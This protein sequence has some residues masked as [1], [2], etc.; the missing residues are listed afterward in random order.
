MTTARTS[1]FADASR[2]AARISSWTWTF[3]AFIFG[4]SSRI[5]PTP[6]RTVRLTNSP[7]TSL[8]TV[9]EAYP[10]VTSPGTVPDQSK[11]GYC[12]LLQLD[13]LPRDRGAAGRVDDAERAEAHGAI[14]LR[15]DGRLLARGG[16][17]GLADRV[18]E[19]ADH[20]GVQV[21]ADRQ[22][23]LTGGVRAADVRQER[24]DL[25]RAVGAGHL[26]RDAAPGRTVVRNA[27]RA[28]DGCHQ[29]VVVVDR[30]QT[31]GLHL[32]TLVLVQDPVRRG[33]HPRRRR[34]AGQTVD[35]IRTMHG[36]A[37]HR[38]TPGQLRVGEPLPRVDWDLPVVGAQYGEDVAE[39]A[40]L[41][42]GPQLQ[43]RR[44]ETDRV[45]DHEDRPGRLTGSQH[46]LAVGHLGG[47][48]LLA[49]HV[50]AGSGGPLDQCT[51]TRVLGR[52]D[53]GVR[54]PVEQLVVAVDVRNTQAGGELGAPRP[55]VGRRCAVRVGG[56]HL[57]VRHRTE[58]LRVR[59]RVDVRERSDRNL[60]AHADTPV[61]TKVFM[62]IVRPDSIEARAASAR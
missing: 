29:P 62:S 13:S 14:R 26:E 24:L 44:R 25:D 37:D 19:G 32:Y 7:I 2:A 45:G 3:S 38:A 58:E 39:P 41:H 11:Q 17:T 33:V 61:E 6:S 1:S 35:E 27:P 46:R 48:R 10:A 34:T 40:R 43:V 49:Q 30:H 56:Q 57:D 15:Y 5:V 60:Q 4:R 18:E 20:G 50:D 9:P 59:R 36:V 52:D 42:H 12:G 21:A 16:R 54:S 22:E 51:V 23:H 53:D 31:A 47:Q 55:G 28:V 8:L